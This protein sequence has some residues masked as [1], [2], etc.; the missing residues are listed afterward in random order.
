[1]ITKI[2]ENVYLVGGSDLTDPYDCLVYLVHLDAGAVLIDAGAGCATDRLIENI[3]QTGIEPKKLRAVVLTHCHIDHIGGAN[4]IRKRTGSKIYAHEKDSKAIEE[5][6]PAFTVEHYY[7]MALAPIPIDVKLS[8]EAGKFDFTSDTLEWI[9]TPGHTPGSIAVM[10]KN[11]AGETVLF[12]QD[13]HGP[14][15]PG[16]GSNITDWRNSMKK[17]LDLKPD[18]LCE[19]HFGIFRPADEVRRFIETHLKRYSRR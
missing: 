11:P 5:A 15:E 8:G 17:L 7:G 16:F 13:I 18:I 12:G 6:I 1:M 14:F 10:Y 4:E 9:H 19:G 2:C 3:K